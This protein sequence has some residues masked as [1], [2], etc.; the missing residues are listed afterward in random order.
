VRL[1]GPLAIA[2]GVATEL[3]VLHENPGQ[4]A[5]LPP[6]L[7][8]IGI[9]AAVA[10]AGSTA[11]RVRAAAVTVAFAVLLLAPATW[12][13]QTLGHPTNGTF[14]TG[15]PQ[16]AGMGGFGG[17]GGPGGNG[18]PGGGFGR[19]GGGFGPGGGRF[20]PGAGT[21]P[22]PGTGT[23]PGAPPAGAPPQG[24]AG[25]SGRGGG[26]FGGNSQ[27]LSQAVSYAQQHG[28]GTV[29]VSS[30]SGAAGLL[31]ASGADIAGI[32]GF[33]GNESQVSVSWL[34]NEIE[35]GHIRWVMTDGGSGGIAQGRVGS[36]AVM[37]AVAKVCTPVS[38]VSGLYDCSNSAAALRALGT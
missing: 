22:G 10:L 36:T 6:L 29:A 26:G 15:G 24:A 37:A 33:S 5:W 30:Q 35:A 7:I 9:V 21:A 2:G 12:A 19:G 1:L 13:V 25:G 8:G 31:I 16:S 34:A 23:A 28:G 3:V 38:S 14:P 4:L 32:G 18:G 17:R 11:R 20:A 27:A